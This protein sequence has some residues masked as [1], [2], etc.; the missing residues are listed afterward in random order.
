MVACPSRFRPDAL[1][2]RLAPLDTLPRALWLG[3]LVHNEGTPI[4]RPGRVATARERL[5]AAQ[6]PFG[7]Q[8]LT[9]DGCAA[10]FEPAFERLG[11]QPL[12]RGQPAVTDEV[13]RSLLWHLDQIARTCDTVTR[14]QALALLAD[15]FEAQWIERGEALR[16]VM[17]LV[18]S[19]DGVV[20]AA[21]W[22]E[23]HGLLESDAWHEILAARE[24][25][26]RMPGLAAMI[27]ELGR[28]RPCD[29]PRIEPSDDTTG[30]GP[31]AWVREP[32]EAPVPGAPV[33]IDG[34]R[35]S[36]ML[37]TVLPTELAWRSKGIAPVRARALRRLFAARLAEQSLLSWRH[38]EY[39]TETH[40]QRRPGP[41]RQPRPTQRPR[42]EAG[43]IVICV[44]TSASMSGGPE[45]VAKAIVVHTLRVAS[46]ERRPCHL[47]A[48]SGAGEVAE[49]EIAADLDGLQALARWVSG[50]FHGGTDVTAPIER[51]IARVNTDGWQ[52]ADLMIVSDGEFGPTAATVAAVDAA[53]RSLGLR[54]H[55]V[56]IGDRETRGMRS[57]VDATFWVRDWR[58]FGDRHGQVEPPIHD[59]NLTALY[60]PNMAAAPGQGPVLPGAGVA[61]VA[62][63]R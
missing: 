61:P 57:I 24:R 51:A 2:E 21:R 47:V 23:L 43:P 17:R 20:H 9:D 62:D 10:A 26:E 46:A 48:F 50:S 16:E 40:W 8:A 44:D 32:R 59:R 45:R 28:A 7:Q 18:E 6:S 33:E 39:W 5:L 36:A 37:S 58:R 52:R 4:E 55:G 11:L 53:R 35:Q 41:L 13:L 1:E 27:R 34:I 22:S 38:R 42:T 19:L 14:A 25:I 60:F 29:D 30:V 12:C 3:T 63:P 54:V 15:A 31:D 49:L 56:L